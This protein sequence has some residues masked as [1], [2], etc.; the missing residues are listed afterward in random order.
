MMK[1]IPFALAVCACVLPAFAG[2]TVHADG[3]SLEQDERVRAVADRAAEEA[4]RLWG[5]GG[6]EIG[7]DLFLD[8]DAGAYDAADQ[9]LTGG[10]FKPNGAFTLGSEA[11]VLLQPPVSDAALAEIGVPAQTLR[12]CAHETAHL[13][14]ERLP[15]AGSHPAWL[16]DGVAQIVSERAMRAVGGA[17]ERGADPWTSAQIVRVR[18]AIADGSLPAFA[19]LLNDAQGTMSMTTRYDARWAVCAWMEDLGAFDAVLRDARRFGGGSNYAPRLN[20]RVMSALAGA[21][22]DEPDVAF[23]AWVGEQRA[24]WEEVYRCLSV[25]PDAWTQIAFPET[26]AIAWTTGELANDAYTLSGSVEILAGAKHQMNVLLARD[27]TGFVSVA[28]TA[29]WGVTVFRYESAANRWTRLASAESPALAVGRAVAFEVAASGRHFRVSLDGAAVVEGDAPEPL[30]GPWGVG[31]QAGS[32]GLWR[33]VVFKPG[34]G[35]ADAP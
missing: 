13:V 8:R 30:A 21:G 3:L 29:G 20:S 11:H 14:R 16:K 34:A 35:G 4:A 2:V 33:G 32:A 28:L 22:V 24:D 18:R 23:R 10:R 31:A 15:N 7:G 17:G 9:R 19:D 26:N 5:F 1:P 27:G 12:L 25:G 6:D